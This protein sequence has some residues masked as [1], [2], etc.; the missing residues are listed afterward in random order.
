MQTKVI[1][2]GLDDYNKSIEL[3]DKILRKPLGL[4]YDSDFLATEKDQFHLGIFSENEILGVLL[5]QIID[6]KTLKM[7]QV[8]VDEHLQGTGIGRKLVGFSEEF[9]KQKGFQKI[10]L[11]ARSTAVPFYEKLNYKITSNMF[12]EVGIEHFEM[13][14]KL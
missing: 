6:E 1:Q 2:F 8:A 7:R 4:E 13:E 11:H 14:K 9:A 12:L 10:I 5:L 3:R